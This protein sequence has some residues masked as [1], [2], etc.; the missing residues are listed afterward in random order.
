MQATA[1]LVIF[2]FAQS[3]LENMLQLCCFAS[4]ERL[5]VRSGAL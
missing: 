1:A 3:V 4:D 5:V 2:T